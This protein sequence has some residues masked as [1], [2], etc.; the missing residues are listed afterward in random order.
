MTALPAALVAAVQTNC[1]IADAVH[2]PELS[3][4]TYLLQMR[5]FYRWE[6][7]LPLGAPLARDVVGA[8]LAAREGQWAELE[9][10]GF[11][12]LPAPGPGPQPREFD[13]FDAQALNERLLPRGL[14]YGAGLAGA[15]RPAFFLA[16]LDESRTLG[17]GLVVQVCGQE[18]ARGL[19]APPAALIG[20]TIVLRRESLARWLWEK[21]EVFGL[22]RAN[23]PFKAVAEAYG[24]EQDFHAGLPRMIDEQGE[25]L[26][27]HERGEHAVGLQLGPA[28]AAM[29]MALHNRRTELHVR[30]V[31]DQLADMTLT[32]PTLLERGAATCVHFWFAAYDGVRQAM[33]PS[34]P[35]AYQAWCRG[36]QGD[37][38]RRAAALG[39]RHF[40]RLAEQVLDVHAQHAEPVGPAIEALLTAPES[41]CRG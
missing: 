28:W 1:H 14:V 8:W 41:I 31:R 34:L 10:A 21:F 3:L 32:L 24:L 19:F 38:L 35:Q 30:A 11:V 15:E 23:G 12:P 7:R 13:A 26:I 40:R 25:M 27:L 29:R 22:K 36:D 2:A 16:Q 18:H 20:D 37:A 9:G 5:E 4:C 17:D 33:Y 6:Q 39:E